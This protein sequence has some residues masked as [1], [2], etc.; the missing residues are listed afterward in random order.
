MAEV[1]DAMAGGGNTA[2]GGRNWSVGGDVDGDI[3]IEDFVER[4]LEKH[5]DPAWG[6]VE[7]DWKSGRIGSRECL[8]RQID[9]V[10]CSPSQFARLATGMKI[11]PGFSSF[12]ALCRQHLLPLRLVSDGL[13]GAIPRS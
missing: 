3:A 12:V 4:L 6:R 9:M 7:E 5:A 2:G 11:D 10:R 1:R 8:A 13:G